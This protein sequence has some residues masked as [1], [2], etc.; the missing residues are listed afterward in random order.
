M[1]TAAD[2]WRSFDLPT[3]SEVLIKTSEVVQINQN[4]SLTSRKSLAVATK[5]FRSR[6]VEERLQDLGKFVKKYQ[7]KWRRMVKISSNLRTIF[8]TAESCQNRKK[9]C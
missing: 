5:T 2:F 6:P 3:W 8:R 4:R 1:S 9:S 7:T